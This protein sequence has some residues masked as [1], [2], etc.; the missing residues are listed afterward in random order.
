MSCVKHSFLIRD[1]AEISFI[2]EEAVKIAKSGR[3]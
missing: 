2:V 1:V 3:P